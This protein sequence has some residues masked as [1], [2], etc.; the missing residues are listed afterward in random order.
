MDDED[1]EGGIGLTY[2]IKHE[3]RLD[4]KVPGAGSVGRGHQHSEAAYDEG[5]QGCY[6]TEAGGEVEAEEG[7]V[8]VQE[9]ARPNA[10]AIDH[11]QQGILH[12]ADAQHASR[13]LRETRLHAAEQLDPNDEPHQHGEHRQSKQQGDPPARLAEGADHRAER[14]AGTLEEGDED[15]YLRQERQQGKQQDEQGVDDSFRDYRADTQAEVRSLVALEHATTQHFAHTR[16]DEAAGIAQEDGMS[17]SGKPRTLAGWGQHLAPTHG[18]EHL[19]CDAK[20]HAQEHPRPRHLVRQ[21]IHKLLPPYA[22]VHPPEYADGQR[23]R[24]CDL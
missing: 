4:G 15:G 10:Y 7:E 2:A 19:G 14:H 8:E 13:E 16:H 12:A 3:D 18:A 23:Q 22:A 21:S 9:V 20:R 11:E 1:E 24:D 5:Y 6:G 17:A